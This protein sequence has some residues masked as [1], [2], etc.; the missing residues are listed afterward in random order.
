MSRAYKNIIQLIIFVM[1]FVSSSNAFAAVCR[2]HCPKPSVTYCDEKS[3]ERQSQK[4]ECGALRDNSSIEVKN[5]SPNLEKSDAN[6]KSLSGFDIIVDGDVSNNISQIQRNIDVQT[7]TNNSSIQVDTLKSEPILSVITNRPAFAYG[8]MVEF[9]AYSNYGYFTKKSEI[10]IFKNG[11]DNNGKPYIVLPVEMG[12]P[13]LWFPKLDEIG[14]YIYSLRVYDKDNH[15]DETAP[16][17]FRVSNIFEK[18]DKELRTG[19]IFDNQRQIKNIAA[20]GVTITL[21]GSLKDKNADISLYNSKAEIDNDGHYFV[22]QIVPENTKSVNYKIKYKNGVEQLFERPINIPKDDNFLVAIADITAGHRSW[23]NTAAIEALNGE[24]AD[25]LSKNYVD[26]RLAFYYKGRFNSKYNITA[27]ADTGEHPLKDLFSQFGKKDTQSFLRRLDPERHYPVYGDDSVLVEDAPT[28]GRFYVR[29]DDANKEFLWGN[30]QTALTGSELVQYSRGVYG[31]GFRWHSSN[32]NERGEKLSKFNA[33]AADPGTINSREEFLSTGG[34]VYYLRHQDIV[35]GSERIFVETRD[36]VS[37]IVL[38]RKELIPAQDYE[39][40]YIQGR[41]L[42]RDAIGITD[43]STGFV[44]D[45]MTSGNPVYLVSMYEYSPGLTQTKS[46]TSGARFEKWVNSNIRIGFSNYHQGG[47]QNKLDLYGGDVLLRKSDKTYI[48]I[49]M[50]NSKGEGDPTYTSDTGGIA[51]DNIKANGGSANAYSIDASLG[52]DEITKKEGD[53]KF[54]YRNRNAGYSGAGSLTQSSAAQQ[55]GIIADLKISD[56]SDLVIKHDSND[57]NDRNNKVT[58]IGVSRDFSNKYYVKLGARYDSRSGNG[59]T[60]SSYL[61]ENGARTDAAVTI[62]YHDVKIHKDGRKTQ[63]Y[64][65]YIFGQNTIEKDEGRKPNNRYG[66]GGDMQIGRRTKI[67]GEISDGD[68]GTGAKAGIEYAY[69]K[70]G[71]LAINYALAAENPDSFNTGRLGRLSTSLRNQFSKE[72]F[73]FAEARYDSGDGPTGLSQAYGVDYNPNL[74][75]QFGLRIERA[76]LSSTTSGDIVRNAFGASAGYNKDYWR[77][78][79]AIEY[80]HDNYELTKKTSQ[81]WAMRNN[82]SVKPTEDWRLYTKFNLARTY[83]NEES[84]YDANYTEAVVAGAYR[85]VKNDRFN[86]LAKFTYL[87]DLPSKGQLSANGSQMDYAQKSYVLALDGTYQL[88]EYIATGAKIAIK[89][90]QIRPSRDTSAAWQKLDT[91]F[92]A[93]RADV[94]IVKEWDA[95]IEARAL[96]IDDVKDTKSGFLIGIYHD[97]G[98]NLKIGLGYNFT[99]YSDNLTDLSYNEKGAF[100]NIISKF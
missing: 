92:M 61:N 9:F 2:M 80:R 42:L 54:H 51:F 11:N 5:I 37:G 33:F 25:E 99:D 67:N 70:T 46:F 13:A 14:D 36:K 3:Q 78:N 79:S 7:S 26:G 10:L 89:Q 19:P 52:L 38:K 23:D 35:Q 81:T 29:L 66:F 44:S 59:L 28:Y 75:W 34:S 85:P 24:R 63:P 94:K 39:V 65:I 74:A 41:V 87:R 91:Q 21:S 71:S 4:R 57:S 93:I 53:I 45:G 1:M 86:S 100:F 55:L 43:G 56:K 64:N 8:D 27:S 15:Y 90:S 83:G 76:N 48:K 77:T 31:A 22:Q 73:G 97:V 18:S 96:H 17:T 16:Q 72:I 47:D 62:G 6:S 98:K 12:K 84:A 95:L 49:E 88:N 58:E 30:F 60:Q 82:L 68:L 69:S 50:A 32:T 40:N 20:N